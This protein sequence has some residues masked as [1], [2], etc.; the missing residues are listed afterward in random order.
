M[1]ATC[2]SPIVSVGQKSF[3]RQPVDGQNDFS[4]A[5]CACRKLL[6]DA[7]TFGRRTHFCPAHA[8]L[9]G[10]H[11]SSRLTHLWPAYGFLAGT[12]PRH[13]SADCAC[14]PKVVLRATSRWAE[15]LFAST[16]CVSQT[17]RRRTHFRPADTLPAGTRP[18]HAS[19]ECACRPEVV[20]RATSRWA[21]RLF[22]GRT[23]VSQTSRR[24]N[25]FCPA[26]PR[27]VRTRFP[28]AA[29]PQALSRRGPVPLPTG[30]AARS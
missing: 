8:L 5:Q 16:T 4:Q 15:R 28:P 6:A 24:Q 1:P 27:P 23:C 29:A 10:A 19:A 22:A 14:R 13:A 2:P 18:R 26:Q 30:R 11:S 12:R 17:S 3:C 20:L 21:E 7:R 9:A 25:H